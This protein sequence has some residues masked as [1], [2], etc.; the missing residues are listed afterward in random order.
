MPDPS[1]IS[2][3]VLPLIQGAGSLFLSFCLIALYTYR[4]QPTLLCWA[5]AWTCYSIWIIGDPLAASLTED[6][7]TG[8]TQLALLAGWWHAA[9]WLLGLSYLQRQYSGPES[10]PWFGSGPQGRR[11]VV[12]TLLIVAGLLIAFLVGRVEPLRQRNAVLLGVSLA[13][14]Y[15]A[16]ALLVY[17]RA[18][19]IRRSPLWLLC[20]S[21]ALFSADRLL[22]AF[23]PGGDVLA[24]VHCTAQSLVAV[25]LILSLFDAEQAELRETVQRLEESEAQFRNIFEHSGVGMTLLA[26]DGRILQANPALARMLGYAPEELCGQR[27]ADF[28][29][30][31]DRSNEAGQRRNGGPLTDTDTPALYE[32][33]KR[34]QRKDGDSIWARVLRVPVRDTEGRVR[35]HVGVLVDITSRKVAEDK[36]AASEQRYR[37]LNQAAHDGIYVTDEDGKFL[38]VNPAF[39]RML[40]QE[41][42]TLLRGRLTD[43]GAEP[44]RLAEFQSRVVEERGQRL[45]TRLRR[46]DGSLLDVELSG[47]LLDLEDRRLLHG[48]CRDVSERKQVEESLRIVQE[49]LREERDF[50]RQVLETADVLIFVTD[51]LGRLIH[52]NGA[53]TAGF[54]YSEEEIR[55]RFFWDV[56]LPERNVEL[57]RMGHY[58]LLEHEAT[59]P[60]PEQPLASA[61]SQEM[62][63]RTRDG[64]ERL[65]SWRNAVVRD[66]A[67]QVRYIIA[68]GIDVTE[69]RAMEEQLRQARKMES[70]G[71]LV[72]GIAHD[73][74]NQLTVVLG[75]LEL[76]RSDL[77]TLYETG[78][79]PENLLQVEN[80]AQRCAEITQRLLTFS[81]GTVS[82][83]SREDPG[84]I[85][86]SVAHQLQREWQGKIE[87]R[88]E[89]GSVWLVLL[90]APQLRQVLVNL[91][92]NARDAMPAGG[93][94]TL[95]VADRKLELR[96]CALNVEARPGRFVEVTVSDTGTGMT[97]DVLSRLFEP[98]FTTKD[99]GQGTG[100]GLATVYGIVKAHGGW[101]AVQS[102][103]GQGST[104]RL[105]LP[106]AEGAS[107][108]RAD[109]PGR[110]G[111]GC[112]LVV[113]DEVLVRGL[114]ETVLQRGGYEVLLAG[115]GVE[116]VRIFREKRA[117][118]DLVLLDYSM[119]R[120]TG[121]EAM[122][123]M[124][125]LDP[126]VRV[127]FSSGFT[128]DSD[129]TQLMATGA[130]A[131]VPKPYRPE[132]LL[133]A[134]RR[135]LATTAGKP[136]PAC[137]DNE[138][139]V[140]GKCATCGD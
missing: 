85:V 42:D 16:S 48:I 81:G 75:H 111:A 97:P 115:D 12:A 140:E 40:S 123:E 130:C 107:P 7:P 83:S 6:G 126:Q 34:Y 5:L 106:A 24:L 92:D 125:L 41:R 50:G 17:R 63:W 68:T 32:R 131:F 22:F 112:I 73:F 3:L 134:V 136:S 94:L 114:A 33:E 26:R 113:D 138:D 87:V 10:L 62:H 96:D 60:S 43:L 119:P 90:D 51:P 37:L 103:V 86:A 110:S 84:E 11:S 1:T 79:L 53:C 101:I 27:L 124:Q 52:F 35:H 93:T 65:V 67:G 102:E 116:G 54:G 15:L 72:G 25:A 58:Q 57:V 89:R 29:H 100:L 44:A 31:L 118:I 127:I 61:V 95:R 78:A 71:T 46:R 4:R 18:V 45:E 66:G 137:R 74:N 129:A 70:L 38:D 55:G 47:A 88:L 9:F 139:Y 23:G 2:T 117:V 104:F 135:I 28:I 30:S 13:A 82:P 36:L 105:F 69:Q 59:P 80:A 20:S 49:R 14:I 122:R 99:I 121:L 109:R 64:V 98:F 91:T 128:R 8:P 21:L 56:L 77:K 132:E 39:C 120:M 76:A 108:G 133:A 19:C